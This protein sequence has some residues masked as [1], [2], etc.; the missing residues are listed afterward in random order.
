MSPK[1]ATCEMLVAVCRPPRRTARPTCLP[2]LRPIHNAVS[3][4]GLR[5]GRQRFVLDNSPLRARVA[6]ARAQ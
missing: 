6:A 2:R 4:A 1:A 5:R 3:L